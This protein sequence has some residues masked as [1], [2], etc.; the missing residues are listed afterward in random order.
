MSSGA[1]EGTLVTT[2]VPEVENTAK[3]CV[4]MQIRTDVLEIKKKLQHKYW[5][6]GRDEQQYEREMDKWHQLVPIY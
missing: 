4:F 5:S 2:P 6:G 1:S 3:K